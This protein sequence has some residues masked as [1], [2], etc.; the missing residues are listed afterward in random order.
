MNLRGSSDIILIIDTRKNHSYDQE[1]CIGDRDNIHLYA[2]LPIATENDHFDDETRAI[3][4]CISYGNI[5]FLDHF[6][7]GC[8][9]WLFKSQA[10]QQISISTI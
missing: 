8:K 2:Q 6:A 7:G 3:P 9:T 10:T 5:M 4:L 1:I